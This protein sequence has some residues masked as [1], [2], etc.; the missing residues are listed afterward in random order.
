[1]VRPHLEY[2]NVIWGPFNQMDKKAV[3]SITKYTN[4]GV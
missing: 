1:M 2:G 3:E 4:I